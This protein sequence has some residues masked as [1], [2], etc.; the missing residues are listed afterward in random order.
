R[1]GFAGI[2]TYAVNSGFGPN[3]VKSVSFFDAMRFVNWLENGQPTRA[4]G[5]GTTEDGVYTIGT[6]FNETRAAGATFFIPS[7]DEWY[8]AAYH[9]P[10]L[11][12]AGGPPG[13]DN[14]WFYSTQSDTAP[15]AEAPPGGVNSANYNQAVG[16]STDVGAYTGTTSFYGTFDQ[17]GNVWE[18]NEAVVIPSSTSTPARALR[19]GHWSSS[20]SG[21]LSAS[22]RSLGHPWVESNDIGFRVAS[23]PEPSTLLLSLLGL[24]AVG[25]KRP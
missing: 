11:A 4:Q 13:D 14:Y 21:N 22:G 24:A 18:W 5:P 23:I 19:S 20:N 3:P 9:D 7:E 8:K 2:F 6:G 15:T 10:R 16:N 25:I 1:S 12:A 17:A